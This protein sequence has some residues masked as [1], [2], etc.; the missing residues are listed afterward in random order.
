M[1]EIERKFLVNSFPAEFFR[2]GERIVQYYLSENPEIRIRKK[3]DGWFLTRKVGSGLCREE[4][5]IKI[6]I[7]LKDEIKLEQFPK[8][9]KTRFTATIND[10]VYSIDIL[11]DVKIIVAEVEFDSIKSANEFIPEK[12]CIKELTGNNEFSSAFLSRFG[13]TEKASQIL[14]ENGC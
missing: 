13:L 3:D 4:F 11:D 9:R 10:Y 2:N 5:E 6:D 8:L 14:I 7:S 1:Q 12:W